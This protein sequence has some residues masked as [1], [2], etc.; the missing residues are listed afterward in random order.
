MACSVLGN[1]WDGACFLSLI[2]TALAYVYTSKNIKHTTLTVSSFSPQF[3]R[4]RKI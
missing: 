4:A 3:S 2:S 1:E